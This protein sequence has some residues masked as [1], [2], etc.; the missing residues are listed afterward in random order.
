MMIRTAVATAAV[1]LIAAC[2]SMTPTMPSYSQAALPAP[3]QV[4]AESR[5]AWG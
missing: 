4:P 5:T 1:L 2:G 3:V